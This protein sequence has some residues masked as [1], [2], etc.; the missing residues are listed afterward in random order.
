[1][2]KMKAINI[3]DNKDLIWSETEKPKILDNE[4]LIKVEATAVNRA[5]VVQKNGFYPPPP[6][7]SNILGLEC[8]GVIEEI[9]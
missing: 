8:S 5:D 4:I 3:I 6:G 7:A 9:G 1:M 2:K